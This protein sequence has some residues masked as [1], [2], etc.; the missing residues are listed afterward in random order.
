MIAIFESLR[1]LL[2]ACL[3]PTSISPPSRPS[4]TISNAHI[5]AFL[6]AL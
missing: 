2:G 5:C 1:G 3:G 6:S 4:T